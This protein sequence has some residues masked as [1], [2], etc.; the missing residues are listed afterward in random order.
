MRGVDADGRRIPAY[1]LGIA[2]AVV[3]VAIG[4]RFFDVT[5]CPLRRFLAI[6]CPTCGTTRAVFALFR[7]NVREAFAWNPLT[8]TVLCVVLPLLGVHALARGA[9]A[10]RHRIRQFSRKRLFWLTLVLLAAANWAY[11]LTKG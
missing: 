9:G 10:T 1:A 3:F 2:C 6:P 7:W 11:L 4:A 8:T 5:L